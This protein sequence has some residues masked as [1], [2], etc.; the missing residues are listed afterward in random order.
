MTQASWTPSPDDILKTHLHAFMQQVGI[1]DYQALYQWS[2]HQPEDF[3]KAF[4]EYSGIIF[5]KN[6]QAILKSHAEMRK[7][8]WFVGAELNF[9]ENLLWCA[10]KD[11]SKNRPALIY[12][13]EHG[14]RKTISYHE[15][16]ERALSLAGYL[17][18]LG[19]T[20][21]D[22]IA[23]FVTNRIETVIAMLATASLGALWSTCGPELGAAAVIERFSQIT[24]KIL[25]YISTHRY[26]G[27]TFSHDETIQK[28]QKNV[29][30]IEEIIDLDALPATHAAIAIEAFPFNHPLYILYSSGTTGKPK[31][32][33]HGAG[34]TLLQH[35]KELLLH[36]DVHEN[37][38]VLFYTSCSWMMWHWMISNLSLGA[39]IILYDGAPFYRDTILPDLIDEY[40]VSI[41]GCGAKILETYFK[42][43]LCLRKTHQFKKLKT[44]LATASPLI[45]ET[46]SYLYR[47]VKKDVR[48]S[49]ISGGSDI[50]SCFAL[51]N[52]LL[53]VYSEEMQC[54]G[55]GMAVEIFDEAGNAVID[56][57]GELVCTQP[58]PSM[59]IY[60]WNDP[61]GEKYFHAYF[62]KFPNVWT[63][64]DFAKI[65][66]QGSMIIYGRSDATLNP[67]GVRI[68]TAD[69]YEQVLKI[70]EVADCVAVGKQTAGDEVIILF[71]KLKEN[72]LL[73]EA[74]INT[75][76]KIIRDNT[77]PH[78]VPQKII[79]VSDIPKTINGKTMEIAVKNI[80]NGKEI[81]N[82]EALA[83]PECLAEFKL[84]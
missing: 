6:A 15:L 13:N 43:N 1:S 5:S 14:D 71:V 67:G 44:I 3:W 74:L 36:T 11:A 47:D 80:V 27:K 62:D 41:F 81:K 16:S 4:S 35:K 19:V 7:T 20:K 28:L 51:G 8:Q 73:D 48:V 40:E 39:T 18:S 77:S 29:P 25:F 56:Q 24:P 58:F 59:P 76:K 55:L 49:S 70:P 60:F 32:M 38:H 82:I 45:H 31:C 65:T 54:R 50:I 33:V 78:H 79:Q 53:P 75:I 21:G 57:P 63:H 30:S 64:G 52:P 2:I 12:T 46:F 72:S 84:P 68:G 83:N 37:D 69:I 10:K 61:T 17:Q 34:N 23:G 66:P 9:S 26:D 42:K 22:R